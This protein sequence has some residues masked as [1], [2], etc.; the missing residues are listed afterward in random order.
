LPEKKK[1]FA[2]GNEPFAKKWFEIC[3]SIDLCVCQ[4]NTNIFFIRKNFFS[5]SRMTFIMFFRGKIGSL[6][7]LNDG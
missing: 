1:E 4:S 5:D 2:I 3:A 6:L 7:Q